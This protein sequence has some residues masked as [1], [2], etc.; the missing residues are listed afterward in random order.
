MATKCANCGSENPEGQRFCGNCG[1][2]LDQQPPARLGV[3]KCPTCGFDNPEGKRF[4]VDCGSMIPRTP[5]TALPG[6]EQEK[7]D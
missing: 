3:V 2:G 7:K 1:R 4:C 6:Q 5:R